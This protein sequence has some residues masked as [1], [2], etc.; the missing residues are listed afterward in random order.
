VSATCHHGRQVAAIARPAS[1]AAPAS[2]QYA[3]Q[4][5]YASDCSSDTKFGDREMHRCG[6]RCLLALN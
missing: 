6:L 2:E 5:K 1:Q 3:Y 4:Q